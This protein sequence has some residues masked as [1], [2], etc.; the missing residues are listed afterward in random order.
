MT[1]KEIMMAK[2]RK[3]AKEVFQVLTFSSLVVFGNDSFLI[4]AVE[5]PKSN[6][7]AKEINDI[8]KI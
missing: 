1:L 4:T 6:T 3:M 7:A 8:K 2:N 5:M